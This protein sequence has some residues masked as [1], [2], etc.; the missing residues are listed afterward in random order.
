MNSVRLTHG[1]A[2]TIEAAMNCGQDFLLVALP[3]AIASIYEVLIDNSDALF[4]S[5]GIRPLQMTNDK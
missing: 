4:P 3:D 1:I 5:D 2:S